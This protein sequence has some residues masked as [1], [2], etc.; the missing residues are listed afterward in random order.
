M[1]RSRGR[2]QYLCKGDEGPNLLSK[3]LRE[4]T[5]QIKQREDTALIK[6]KKRMGRKQSHRFLTIRFCIS[7]REETE[8]AEEAEPAPVKTHQVGEVS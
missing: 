1:K 3:V 8:A 2:F 5:V 4:D 7:E 6:Q